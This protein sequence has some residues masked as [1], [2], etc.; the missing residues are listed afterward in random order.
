MAFSSTGSSDPE[1]GALSYSWNFGDGSTSTSAAPSHTYTANGQY[2]A[3]LTVRD[4]DGDTGTA[5]LPITVGNTAP[6]VTVK[7]PVDGTLFSFGDSVPY[8]ITVTDPEDGTI[9]CAKVKM[10]Y[11]LGHDNH[12]HAVTSKNGCTGSITV[13]VDGEHD[14]AANIFGVWD[15]EYTDAG[16]GGR[17]PLTTHAQSITQ[18]RHRQ[19]EHFSTSTGVTVMN[20]PAAQGGKTVGDIHNGDW[21]AFTPYA[22]GD[23]RR[24]SA[25]VSSAG[26]GGTLEVRAGSAT[27]TLLGSVAVPVTGG[28]DT[29][30]TVNATLSG[31]PAG[32]T[33]LYLVFKGAGSGALYDVDSFDLGQP[34]RIT[35]LAGKCADV[36]GAATADGTPVQL[37]GCNGTDAQKWS[38]VGQTFQALGKCMDVAGGATA[39]GTPVQLYG[40]NG[41]GA[42]RW[43]T[44]T[45]GTLRNPQSGRC[46][47]VPGGNSADGTQL[48]LYDCVP[49]SP[50]EQ[51]VMS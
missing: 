27:G 47:D 22:L 16:A 29:F 19:A 12:G 26:S 24:L 8:E 14:D 50:N 21:I 9:D 13:P 10:T 49:T 41:T 46:L 48:A 17:P 1:G 32:T 5:S 7:L 51:W 33:T 3:V 44:H 28:W 2:T 34:G 4:P 37:Y 38:R 23:A 42:Q 15:A 45:N 25:R 31:A 35:G 20:K 40:C 11:V 18:P 43:D 36:R 30:T 6:T 39:N